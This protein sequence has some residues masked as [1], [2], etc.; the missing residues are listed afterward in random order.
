MLLCTS[1]L[2]FAL[3]PTHDAADWHGYSRTNFTVAGKDCF[4]THPKIAAPGKP[5]VWRTSFPDFHAEVD[6][7]LLSHGWSVSYIE[8]LDMLGCDA[9][10]NV[11]DQF[12]DAVT[13]PNGLSKKPALEGVSHG[14][15]H[16]YRYAARHPERIACIYADTPVMDLASWP[17]AH[18][19]SKQQVADALKYYG[20]KDV[21][22]LQAYRGN[23]IDL[24][25]PIAK[26][27]IPLRHVISLSDQVVPPEQ[28]TLEA[29]RRLEK[30]GHTMDVVTVKEGTPESDGHHFPLPDAFESARFIMQHTTVLPG[31][32]D[33][34]GRPPSATSADEPAA[35]A[36]REYFMLRKGLGNSF[37]KFA[38]E[39]TG[40]VAFLGGS[41]TFNPGWRDTVMRYL[42]QRFPDTKFDFIAAG[43][44]SLGSVPHAF[45][46]ENDV[47]ARGPVDLV[48]VEAAVND[49]NHDGD[50][51]QAALALRG[52]E[53]V[54]RHLRTTNALTDVVEMHFIHNIH[55]KTWNER[56][57]PYTIAAHERVAEHYGCPSLNLSL[58]V[59]DRINAKELTWAGDFRD[60]HPSPYG[61][62]LYANSITRMLDAAC[63]DS[64]PTVRPHLCPT[65]LDAQSYFRGRFGDVRTAR[66]ISGFTLVPNWKPLK[67]GGTRDGYVNVPALVGEAAGAEFEY[68]FEGTTAG[69]MITSGPDAGTIEFTVDGGLW[70]Q[71]KTRTQW[72][73]DLHLPWALMLDDALK[74]GKHTVRVRIATGALRVFHLLLN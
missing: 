65:P 54:V 50:P 19:G 64:V 36:H 3:A 51:N 62:Q 35:R 18:P 20:F 23:P 8:C 31:R 61:Q 57:V 45:R 60:L 6:L 21:A 53:G 37:V 49:H 68:S 58:E 1:V 17:V 46:L 32:G 74:P 24:L 38:K 72:S 27:R 14:G 34:P 33:P 2:L 55:F 67:G 39:K 25:A 10:L 9:S 43:S 66:I 28:N 71:A 59:N 26:A 47:L 29:K 30:L 15:L 63:T 70:K 69:L 48:F 16:A 13:S 41:I 11:M 42:Q 56:K 7:E 5:W 52:M 73:G 12:Y 22:A 4:V 40:R 44:P